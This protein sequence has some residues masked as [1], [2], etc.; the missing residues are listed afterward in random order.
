MVA[1]YDLDLD[2]SRVA[3]DDDE[4]VGLGNL[5][6]RGEDGWIGGVGVVAAAR[7]R[8][9]GETLMRALHAEAF[10]RDVRRVWLEVIDRNESAHELYVKLRYRV[11]REIEVW[12]LGAAPSDAAAQEV[13]AAKAHA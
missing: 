7:R 10:E 13:P 9:I 5:G 2:A 1:A 8:G 12:S 3:F 6:L 11:V 4:A